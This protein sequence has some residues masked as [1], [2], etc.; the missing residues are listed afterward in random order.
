MGNRFTDWYC[1]KCKKEWKIA[2]FS[3][4]LIA[5]L[6]HLY[7]FTNALPNHDTLYNYFRTRNRVDLGRWFLCAGSL[8]TSDFS[9]PWFNAIATVFFFGMTMVALVEVFQVKNP[10][11]IC[12]M[13][14]LLVA[15]PAT[16]GTL[17]YQY[18]ADVYALGMFLSCLS[19]ALTLPKSEQPRRTVVIKT[20]AA[21]LLLT[22]SIGIYQS[23]LSF[24]LVL[25]LSFF[26]LGQ[27]R[28]NMTGAMRKKWI[29]GQIVLY[30]C[31][32]ALYYTIW[33]V[34]QA[35]SSVA[36]NDYQG[37]A[38][39]GLS[40]S[41]ILSGLKHTALQTALLFVDH[42]PVRYGI[43][44]YGVIN[45]LFLILALVTICISIMKTRIYKRKSSFVLVLLALVAIPV[46][47]FVWYF[48]SSGVWYRCIMVQSA[49]VF[50]MLIAVLCE[51][52]LKPKLRTAA[53]IV[54]LAVICNNAI[55]ANIAYFY[56]DKAYTSTSAMASEMNM[57]MHLEDESAT[58][59][60]VVG[61]LNDNNSLYLPTDEATRNMP[62]MLREEL[63]VHLLLDQEHVVN[64]INHSFD[65]DY[66]GADK[67][68]VMALAKDSRVQD[69]TVWPAA[70]SV[71]NIDGVMVV[72]VQEVQVDE[73]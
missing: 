45:M 50:Y 26:I 61:S 23:Y 68:T 32:V 16:T 48:A 9:L 56:L 13:S 49:A 55:S 47:V 28:N 10:V 29:V 66:V 42:N 52:Y 25:S 19:V 2:F 64:F 40:F 11:L 59:V 58:I 15:Y 46:A 3:A 30:V 62:R 60:A 43:T 8:L 33:K 57:R 36:A 27:L 31:G 7:K 44:P 20:A 34:F 35:F 70:G 67:D 71:Q 12:L 41:T 6:V 1:N 22:L 4:I 72:K 69:M 24:A 73:Q 18:T 51:E 17:L 21:V 38:E 53:V 65:E 39:I 54:L 63:F 14:G 37:I 5:L